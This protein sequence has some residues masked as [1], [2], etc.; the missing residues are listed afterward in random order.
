MKVHRRIIRTRSPVRISFAGGGTDVSPFCEDYGGNVVNVTINRYAES[1]LSINNKKK[2]E[3]ISNDQN[4]KITGKNITGLKYDGNLD[5]LK[6]TVK[7]ISPL[8]TGFSLYVNSSVAK[9]SGLGGSAA[10][11]CCIIGAFNQLQKEKKMDG[12]NIAE[13]AYDIERKELNIMGG[14]QDQYATVFGGLNYI[15]FKGNDF[16]RVN[17]LKLSNNQEH[18]L[19]SNLLLLNIGPRTNSGD[20]IERQVKNYKEGKEKTKEAF[21][22]TKKIA[23]EVKYALL[24]GDFKRFGQL[25]DEAWKIKK[26]FTNKMSNP[27]IDKIYEKM[28]KTGALG[29]KVTGAGGGGHMIL[30]CDPIKKYRIMK[31][32]RNLGLKI[33]PFSFDNIGLVSWIIRK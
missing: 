3:I 8:K 1:I 15:E 5:L 20:I 21:I 27:Q 28:K 16:V 17:P 19:E 6:A 2:F 14:R 11:T 12:F 31:E 23:K 18:E 4:F 9:R 33:I 30:C 29:G 32:A 26:N 25:L 24:R 10:L 13:T 7:R 22:Q